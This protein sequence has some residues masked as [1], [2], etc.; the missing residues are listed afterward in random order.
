MKKLFYALTIGALLVS[1]TGNDAPDVIVEPPVDTVLEGVITTDKTLTKDKIWEISGRVVVANGATLTI[2]AGT[3]IK[4]FAGSGS[5][6][7]A[8]VI[9]RGSKIN[10]QGTATEPII[11]TS[12]ADNISV[13]QTSGTNLSENDR[14]LWGGLIIL[15]NAPGSFKGDVT[16][17]QIEGIPPTDTNGLFGGS[18]PADNSGVLKYVSIRHGGAELSPDNEINGLTLGAVGNGTVIDNVEVVANVDDGIE[19]F[20]GTVNASN[21]VVWSAGD[22]GIDIDQAYSGTISNSVVILGNASDH[23]LEI[24]GPEGSATGQFIL[25]GITLIGNETTERGE[26]A[27]YRSGA[28]GTTKNV[29]AYGFKADADVELD[30]DGVAANYT[31]GKLVFDNWQII[32]PAGVN[33]SA[34]I[35]ADKSDVGSTF[36]SDAA[37]FSSAVTSSSKTTGADTTKF[38]WTMANV[39]NALE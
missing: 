30:N 5:Q 27:D 8:L 39:K 13:G 7:S 37:N 12:K 11:M 6:A 25:D 15:G 4:A 35:F 2:E 18:N 9:A 38:T 17:L 34:S 10:A 31:S 33:S 20:G 32:L 14:G 23:A 3:I 24:D 21:L 28:M 29:L 26:Y 19:F 16:E 22:D 36:G 1:C